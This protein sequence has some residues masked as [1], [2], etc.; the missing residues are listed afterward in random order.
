MIRPICTPRC[1]SYIAYCFIS[2]PQSHQTQFVRLLDLGLILRGKKFPGFGEAFDPGEIKWD[3][4]AGPF[5]KQMG[6]IEAGAFTTKT[7]DPHGLLVRGLTHFQVATI[8]K[9][10]KSEF[11]LSYVGYI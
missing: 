7:H 5:L 6:D 4:D 2:V 1:A 11:L 8:A 3:I 9:H 10:R